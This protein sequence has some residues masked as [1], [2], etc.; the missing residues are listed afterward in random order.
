MSQEISTMSTLLSPPGSSEANST[1][2]PGERRDGER[3]RLKAET[4]EFLRRLGVPAFAG[5]S[6]AWKYGRIMPLIWMLAFELGLVS[7]SGEI[8]G[9]ALIA[10]APAVALLAFLTRPISASALAIENTRLRWWLPALA[11]VPVLTFFL[12]R[13]T[14]IPLQG[15]DGQQWL[16]PHYWCDA[17]VILVALYAATIFV[18]PQAQAT[19][20]R[21]LVLLWGALLFVAIATVA[22]AWMFPIVWTIGTVKAHTS[23]LPFLAVTAVLIVALALPSSCT[24]GAYQ[25]RSYALAIPLAATVLAFGLLNG[26]L[27]DVLD[28]VVAVVIMLLLSVA[29]V[30]AAVIRYRRATRPSSSTDCAVTIGRAERVHRHIAEPRLRYWI[31]A[32]LVTYPILAYLIYPDGRVFIAG[33]EYAGVGS[34][35]ALLVFN[36]GYL[37]FVWVLVGFGLDTLMLWSAKEFLRK[38]V[39]T[40]AHMAD[41]APLLL[42]FVA[43]VALTAETWQV[44]Y[45]V[46]LGTLWRICGLLLAL[47]AL[48][49]VGWSVALIHH[50]KKFDDPAAV[51]GELAGF[52]EALWK[53]PNGRQSA[54]IVKDLESLVRSRP[55]RGLDTDLGPVAWLNAL[56][57]VLT[58]QVFV[59]TAIAVLLFLL[60]LVLARMAV[61]PG[62][63][64]EWIFGDGQQARSSELP[65]ISAEAFGR[66]LRG[67]P[68][69]LDSPWVRVP[70]L[71]TLFCILQFAA[72][73]LTS[74][75]RRR[76][77]FR[78]IDVA[79]RR[80]FAIRVAYRLLAHRTADRAPGRQG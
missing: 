49:V 41:A 18:L 59:F 35:V 30:I 13:D 62:V 65:G 66:L 55:D 64:A 46:S 22:S 34:I 45:D 2:A 60:F 75:G 76:R 36:A 39:D 73:S 15:L 42:L 29:L 12:I 77:Y 9:N 7:A 26:L 31:P 50:Q 63:A 58:Y 69:A 38:K 71:L 40:V 56:L 44:A 28:Q 48:L 68:S 70:L 24:G 33:R 79:I 4:A 78:G 57:V 54:A 80:R 47:T 8:S 61:P 25:A 19:S 6:S 5:R 16:V 72:Q 11:L 51:A 43:F 32:F 53:R 21:H 37:L 23:I 1:E 17:T 10:S 52:R 20:T 67:D 27:I 14:V 3:E 74:D